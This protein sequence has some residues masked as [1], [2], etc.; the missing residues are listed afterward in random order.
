MQPLLAPREVAGYYSPSLSVAFNN[1]FFFWF[2]DPMQICWLLFPLPFDG[3][4]FRSFS[5]RFLGG[6]SFRLY[7][8]NLVD[9][10]YL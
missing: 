3:F 4:Y 8:K 5:P 7:N 1:F 2:S 6:S 10:F 9:K